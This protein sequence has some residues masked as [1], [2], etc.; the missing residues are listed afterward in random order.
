[1]WIK[2]LALENVKSYDECGEIVFARG[3]NAISGPNGAG[4]STLLEAIGFALFDSLPY[5]QADFLR[6][7]AKRGKVTVSFIDALDEREYELVRPIAGGTISVRDPEVNRELASG[8]DDVT[9]WLKRHL[10]VEATA[11]LRALFEDAIGVPQGLLTATFLE[12]ATTRKKKFDPLLQVDDYEIIWYRLRDALR[13]L[14][15]ALQL[16]EQR[17]AGF[18]GELI[19]LPEVKKNVKK[20]RSEAAQDEKDLKALRKK[21]ESL[22]TALAELDAT[23]KQIE[24]DTIRMETISTLIEGHR[25]QLADAREAVEAAQRAKDVLE[26]NQAA[27]EAYESAQAELAAL[28]GK[29]KQRDSLREMASAVEKDLA[30]TCAELEALQQSMVEIETAEDQLTQY[31]PDAARQSQLEANLKDSLQSKTRLEVARERMNE[32]TQSLERITA[33]LV[34]VEGGLQHRAELEK[35]AGQI[36]TQREI[37]NTELIDLES[38]QAIV[39]H[40]QKQ[41][42]EHQSILEAADEAICP[43]CQQALDAAHRDELT[44]HYT[45]EHAAL[46]EAL[47]HTRSRV[48]GIRREIEGIDERAQAIKVGLASLPLPQQAEDLNQELRDGQKQ[49]KKLGREMD[50]LVRAVDRITT[51]EHELESLGDPRT[52]VRLLQARV[53]ARNEIETHLKRITESQAKHEARKQELESQLAKLHDLDQQ[54]DTANSKREMHAA[55]H[56]RYLEQTAVVESFAARAAKLK[57]LEDEEKNLTEEK[58]SLAEE[59]SGLES[60]YD[61]GEHEQ[62]AVD[63]E[64]HARDTAVLEER[65]KLTRTRMDDLDAEMTLLVQKEVELKEAEDERQRLEQLSEILEFIRKTV[66][67]A[68]P[69]VTRALVQTISVEAHQMYNEIMGDFSMR[70]NWNEDYSISIEQGGNTRTFSQLSGGE[71]MAA[72][73]AVRLA[74]LREMSQIRVAFFDEPTANLDDERRENLAAQITQITGF[75]QL[76]VISHDDTFERETHH[77]IRVHKEGDVSRVEVG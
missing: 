27:Y 8:K 5:T 65:L 62:L 39:E 52:Q 30:R 54:I 43:V 41:I 36:E 40:Q 31:A 6:Q 19:R 33:R 73:L 67:D 68:G 35:Q 24:A 16:Q 15:E 25:K 72:A 50:D 26:A 10:G 75:N 42:A 3:V 18:K 20:I 45:D 23:R 38:D 61:R 14:R 48:D 34:E 70:L 77:I 51:I 12:N 71:K 53:N 64:Q 57:D 66:R 63:H 13:T 22:T 4:K 74:L 28:D 49:S 21:L 58:A 29:R 2:K 59:L 56:R 46:E 1:M 44:K 32:E 47:R 76:F 60:G 17:I 11:D 69:H 9:A 37:L 55:G 7:G